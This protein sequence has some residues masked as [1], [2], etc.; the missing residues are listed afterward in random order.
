MCTTIFI[1]TLEIYHETY[2]ES[3]RMIM[4]SSDQVKICHLNKSFACHMVL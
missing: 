3:G 4:D 2:D 1:K